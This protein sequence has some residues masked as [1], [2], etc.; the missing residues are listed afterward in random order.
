MLQQVVFPNGKVMGET[1]SREVCVR[2]PLGKW[3][4]K[5]FHSIAL[6]LP[7][8][9]PYIDGT[10]RGLWMTWTNGS[11]SLPSTHSPHSHRGEYLFFFLF[12]SETRT[13]ILRCYSIGAS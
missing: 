10:E 12:F 3:E 11:F 13:I 4:R 7:P 1:T 8:V 6:F 5:T 9:D 2:N